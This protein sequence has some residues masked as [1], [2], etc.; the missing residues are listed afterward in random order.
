MAVGASQD[1]GSGHMP[2]QLMSATFVIW[3]CALAMR[4]NSTR[5]VRL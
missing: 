5:P 3:S 2:R 1:V 4:Q